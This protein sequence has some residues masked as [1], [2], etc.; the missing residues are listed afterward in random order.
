MRIGEMIL[1]KRLK[2]DMTLDVV[3][4]KINLSKS[5]LSDIERYGRMPRFDDMCAICEVLSL[6]IKK[7]WDEIKSQYKSQIPV[8][9]EK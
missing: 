1:N 3:S 5:A 2:K 7:V 4:S 9:A 6:D 8:E